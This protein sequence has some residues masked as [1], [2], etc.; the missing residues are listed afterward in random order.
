[1][2]ESRVV[3]DARHRLA[4]DL[5]APDVPVPVAPRGE[6]QQRVVD[7]HQRQAPE[8][9]GGVH[10]GD[11]ATQP[12]R[13]V[14]GV[15]CAEGVRGVDA[16]AHA[17]R[18][19]GRSDDLGKLLEARADY[20]PL[21]GGVLQ[22]HRRPVRRALAGGV[23]RLGDAPDAVVDGALGTDAAQVQDDPGGAEPARGLQLLAQVGDAL[24][25]QPAV[26]G[27]DVQQVLRVYEVRADVEVGEASRE[28]GPLVLRDL[29]ARPLHGGG[30]EHLH[31]GAA[32]HHRAPDT[33]VQATCDGDVEA[34]PHG[35]SSA[36][37]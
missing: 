25:A 24:L 19:L 21:P 30:G 29:V 33:P 27:G 28:L 14:D 2:R 3:D 12:A 5:P 15:A 10:V 35:Q 1:M 34:Q 11:G 20:V 18:A 32:P 7:V 37:A 26:G 6:G 17:L 16:H 13:R 23:N 22:D 31:G 36:R 8:A 9:E 4:P